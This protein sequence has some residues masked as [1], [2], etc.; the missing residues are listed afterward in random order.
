MHIWTITVTKPNLKPIFAYSPNQSIRRTHTDHLIQCYKNCN[1]TLR[2][3]ISDP[4]QKLPL[5]VSNISSTVVYP[6]S[7]R[8]NSANVHR[9]CSRRSPRNFTND[10]RYSY[11]ANILGK[12]TI[13]ANIILY[14]KT[15][16]SITVIVHSIKENAHEFVFICP[17][18]N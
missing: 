15:N 5:I 16:R 7:S 17:C 18:N 8:S 11:S 1:C 6:R 13:Y 14:R 10:A 9:R 2:K 4:M 12:H 3:P